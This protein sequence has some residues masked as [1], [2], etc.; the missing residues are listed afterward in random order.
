MSFPYSISE[1]RKSKQL[2]VR[3]NINMIR[4]GAHEAQELTDEDG[5]HSTKQ[6]HIYRQTIVS[7][8]GTLNSSRQTVTD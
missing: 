5:E 8:R 1:S 6:K 7:E 3:E 4:N 2:A